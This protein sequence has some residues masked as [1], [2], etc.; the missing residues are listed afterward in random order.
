MPLLASQILLNNFLSDIPA[1][2]LADDSVDPELVER[3]ERW[4]IQWIGRFMVEFGILS[5][6]FDI[7]TF[8]VLFGVFRAAPDMFRTAWFVE[9][10]L[11]ELVI[12][13]VMRTRRPFF[14]SRLGRLLLVSTTALIVLTLLIPRLPFVDHLGFVPVPGLLMA[15]LCAITGLYVLATEGTK[16]CFFR[17]TAPATAP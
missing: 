1:I 8:A 5:S 6:F 14:R 16:H 4:N 12:A 11:T 3:P 7:L 13:L 17:S 9:S 15:T 10:L 2:G